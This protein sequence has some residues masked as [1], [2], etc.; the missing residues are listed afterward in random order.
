MITEFRVGCFRRYVPKAHSGDVE[1]PL[2]TRQGL[3]VFPLVHSDIN[4]ERS[5]VLS[6][7]PTDGLVWPL[8]LVLA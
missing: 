7:M 2:P 4:N 8:I 5:P 1:A 6:A 3:S